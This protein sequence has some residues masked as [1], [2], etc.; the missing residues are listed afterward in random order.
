MPHLDTAPVE[1][2]A[3]FERGIDRESPRTNIAKGG[4]EDA[5]NVLLGCEPNGAKHI[6]TV[7]PD[8]VLDSLVSWPAG[9]V[10][11]FVPFTHSQYSGGVLSFLSHLLIVR[12]TGQIHRYDAGAPGTVT[13]VRRGMNTS[14]KL[15]SHT[16]YDQWL[17]LMNG[18]DAPMKYGQHFL[19]AGEARP[20]LFPLGSKPVT[21]CGAPIAGETWTHAGSS[22]F[23]ND[24]LVPGGGSRVHTQSLQVAAASNSRVD[25]ASARNFLSGPFPYGGTD[26]TGSDF[27]VFQVFKSTGTANVRLRFHKTVGTDFFEFTQSVGPSTEWQTVRLSR[28]AAATTGSPTWDSIVRVEFFN[29]DASNPVYVDDV[30]FLYAVAPPALQVATEHKGRLVGGGVPVAGDAV[31]PTLAN[32][33]WSRAGFPDEW[34][35]TNVQVISAGTSALARANRITAVREFGASVLVGTPSALVAWTID[36]NGNPQKQTIT[37]EHGVDSHRAVIETPNGALLLVWQRGLFVLRS[38]WRAFGAEK[39]RPLLKDLWLDEPDWTVAVFD[40]KTQT[41]RFWWREKPA[42]AA[43]PTKTTTGII[44]DYVR[45][46]ELGEGVWTARMTQLADWAIPAYVS[47]QR[48]VLYSRFD[49]PQIFRLGVSESGP[50]ESFVTLPWLSREAKDKLVK[51]AG[52]VVPYSSTGPV[53]AEIRYANNPHEFDTATFESVGVLPASADVDQARVPFGRPARW[54]QVRLRS[55]TYKLEIYPPVAFYAYPTAREP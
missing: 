39:I 29:D 32:L 41:I 43:N 25:F 52:L 20:F 30:Y 45:A 36:A 26:F 47:G 42:G 10:V 23:V 13:T 17:I 31:T 18:R 5:Q 15:Y 11:Y 8:A 51:W 3:T 54:A 34:P 53:T 33:Y 37:N 1:P 12:D 44:L 6:C 14:Q 49:S 27:L 22:G 48:E 16:I 2:F 7:K 46:Q 9:N 40:E 4:Y 21:P 55:L 24:A 50:I 19:K 38:T 28:S 35:T